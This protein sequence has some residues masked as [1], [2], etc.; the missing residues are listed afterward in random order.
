MV[1]LAHV[2]GVPVEEAALTF[3]PIASVAGGAALKR[4]LSPRRT[5]ARRSGPRPRS[6]HKRNRR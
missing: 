4:A 3:A 1:V 5:T 6:R 2:M